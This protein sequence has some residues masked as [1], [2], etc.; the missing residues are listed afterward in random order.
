MSKMSVLLMVRVALKRMAPRRFEHLQFRWLCGVLAL[1]HSRPIP[2]EL[3]RGLLG[4]KGGGVCAL[5]GLSRSNLIPTQLILTG[6][7][8][9]G[10]KL[11]IAKRCPGTVLIGGLGSFNK[12]APKYMLSDQTVT[13]LMSYIYQ[14]LEL[15]CKYRGVCPPGKRTLESSN[16][17]E[18]TSYSSAV[19]LMMCNTKP[20]S[21]SISSLYKFTS[22]R[23]HRLA[24]LPAV[25]SLDYTASKVSGLGSAHNLM[26]Q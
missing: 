23:A 16:N 5:S 4:S 15:I 3:Q 12:F 9:S 11:N 17:R 10:L 25:M 24:D 18:A 20:V 6:C 19:L 22:R 14:G 13:E 2:A 7:S 8:K 1:Q 26:G 21:I